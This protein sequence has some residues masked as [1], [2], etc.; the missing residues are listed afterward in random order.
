[1]QQHDF[2]IAELAWGADFNDAQTFLDLFRTGGGNNWGQYSNP[3]FDALLA[4]SEQEVD[5]QRRGGILMEAEALLLKDEAIVPLFSWVS[6]HM[7][8][9]YVKGWTPNPIGYHRS[10]WLSI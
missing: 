7:A 5:L 4:R 2:D 3:A 9:P 1:T 10:R 8:W 6:P